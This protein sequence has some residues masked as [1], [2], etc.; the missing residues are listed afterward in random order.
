[1]TPPR[2]DDAE[3]YEVGFGKPPA[4]T[5]FQP[6]RSG[7]PK[8]RPKGTKNLK[9]D[10]LEELAESIVV[11]E[12]ERAK[13]VSKQRAVV[14]TLVART[15]QGDAR[16]ATL[17]LSMMTRWLDAEEAP[18]PSEVVP[19]VAPPSNVEHLAEVLEGLAQASGWR[20]V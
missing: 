16:A 19:E 1:M 8:G 15:L 6:G 20:L 18:K 14:K 12:G 9:T 10:L 11:R 7:N 5:R 3:G 13:P 2:D 4:R 17:L